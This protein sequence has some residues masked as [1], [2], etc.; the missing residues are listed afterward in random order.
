MKVLI[1]SVYEHWP[2]GGAQVRPSQQ[3]AMFVKV[4]ISMHW[5]PALAH[6]SVVVVVVVVDV[7]VVEVVVVDVVVEVVVV[8]DVVVEVVVV[9]DVVE[10]VV[11]EE[12]VVVPHE[13]AHTLSQH[14]K[15]VS[16]R[17]L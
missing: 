7:V 8:E 5:V 1:F 6:A 3:V 10:D 11:V 9:E 12:V 13:V 4:L 15:P 17:P 16:Q 2:I 14:V